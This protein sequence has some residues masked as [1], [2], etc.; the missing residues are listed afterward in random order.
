MIS[1]KNI[2]FAAAVLVFSISAFSEQ[3]VFW[4]G[5]KARTKDH[6]HSLFYTDINNP[7]S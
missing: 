6:V 4:S 1:F 3:F 5:K 2:I 7:S